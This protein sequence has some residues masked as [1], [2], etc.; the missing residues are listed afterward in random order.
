MGNSGSTRFVQEQNRISSHPPTAHTAKQCLCQAAIKNALL[1]VA[2]RCSAA[3]S[4]AKQRLWSS[5]SRSQNGVWASRSASNSA[6]TSAMKQPQADCFCDQHHPAADGSMP[7][8]TC[9]CSV[10]PWPCRGSAGW[11][12][13]QMDFQRAVSTQRVSNFSPVGSRL[14][15][16][17]MTICLVLPCRILM[18]TFY[19]TAAGELSTHAAAA[20]ESKEVSS[21]QYLTVISSL[22]HSFT[23]IEHS[24]TYPSLRLLVC[25]L[26][27]AFCNEGNH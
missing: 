3:A 23:T 4:L 22:R 17:S 16:P 19:W 21:K 12:L 2:Y 7:A 6:L 10:L 9:C 26:H 8:L 18:W 20:V 13:C 15:A 11:L 27:P 14:L 5:S 25:R 24:S 1:L